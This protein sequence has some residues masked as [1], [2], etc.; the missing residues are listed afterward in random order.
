M[1]DTIRIPSYIIALTKVVLA[2]SDDGALTKIARSRTAKI[3]YMILT[4]TEEK[5]N[6]GSVGL[7]TRRETAE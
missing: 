4:S 2:G 7:I 3:R 1:L 6:E 5:N